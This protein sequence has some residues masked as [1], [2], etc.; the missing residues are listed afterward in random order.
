MKSSPVRRTQ[1][2]IDSLLLELEE[3]GETVVAFANRRGVS[4]QTV[5][6]WKKRRKPPGDQRSKRELVR[7]MVAGS[8]PATSIAYEL[9]LDGFGTIRVPSGFDEGDLVRLLRAL[10]ERC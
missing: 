8:E 9:V 2:E 3:S 10:R 6:G 4:A 7:V 1:E 5:Y